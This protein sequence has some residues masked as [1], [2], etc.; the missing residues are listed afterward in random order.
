MTDDA[1]VAAAKRG[2]PEA[3]RTLYREHAGRLVVWLRTR[4]TGDTA[5]AAE[6][7]ASEAWTVAAQKIADFEGSS[8]EFGGWLFGIARRIAATTRRTSERR[9]TQPEDVGSYDLEATD[10]TLEVDGQDWVRTALA[11]LP[12]RERAAVG[13]V[14]GL[15]LD[16]RTAAEVLGTTAVAVRVARHRGL[17]RLAREVGAAAPDGPVVLGRTAPGM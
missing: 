8:S 4:P 3:W 9:R 1:V 13:L 10:S 2:D 17:R 14:D 5:C 6:D 12:P 16:A 7:V 11:S 15:G